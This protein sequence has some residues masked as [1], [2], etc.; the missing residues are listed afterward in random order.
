MCATKTPLGRLIRAIA[1]ATHLDLTS[2]KTNHGIV[3]RIWCGKA[4]ASELEN[5][6]ARYRQWGHDSTVWQWDSAA[7]FKDVPAAVF[8]EIGLCDKHKLLAASG[9]LA[10]LGPEARDKVIAGENLRISVQ[11]ASAELQPLLENYLR[12]VNKEYLMRF[13]DFQQKVKEPSDEDFRKAAVMI[14]YYPGDDIMYSPSLYMQAEGV[15]GDQLSLREMD[16]IVRSA[17]DVL[18][19]QPAEAKVPRAW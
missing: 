19:K 5:Y 7:R 18:P 9:I 11:D 10:A 4:L 3:Y 17:P 1:T 12:V 13:R 14:D 6:R 16:Y 15:R 2:Y 8:E